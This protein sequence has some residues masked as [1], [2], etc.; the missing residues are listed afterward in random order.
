MHLILVSNQL[1]VSVCVS[2]VHLR[3]INVCRY[4]LWKGR[5]RGP[6]QS[7][8]S[9]CVSG[10]EMG[11]ERETERV[12]QDAL[13]R[14]GGIERERGGVQTNSGWYG[15][16]LS[17]SFR[18]LIYLPLRSPLQR[19]LPLSP[20]LFNLVPPLSSSISPL[21]LCLPFSPSLLPSCCL[22]LDWLLSGR[23]PYF[24]VHLILC[25]GTKIEVLWPL[26]CG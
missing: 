7:I 11:R 14:C 2:R 24:G 15:L 19:P 1:I 6:Y 21:A 26:L 22:L 9:G 10:D 12:R 18:T 17:Q 4:W 16:C 23:I 25:T 13:M 3:S 5:A 8:T 20:S